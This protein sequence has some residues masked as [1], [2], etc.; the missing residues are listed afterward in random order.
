MTAARRRSTG[1]ASA[2]SRS[3]RIVL[4]PILRADAPTLFTWINDRELVLLNAPYRPVHEPTHRAWLQHVASRTDG[5]TFAIRL[6]GS[7]RLIG[8]CQLNG[9]HPVHRSAEL[10]IRIGDPRWQGRGLGTEAVR[11]LVAFAFEDLNLHRVFL[12]VF[13]TNARAVRAYERAGFAVEGTLRDAV[14]ID[15]RYVDVL[16]MS[17][18]R[19]APRG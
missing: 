2:R 9:V 7:R 3:A 6:E 14:H 10:Q 11:R 12:H 13:A 19:K 15:G 16:V 4:A 17:I 8:I 5:V 18:L 1:A